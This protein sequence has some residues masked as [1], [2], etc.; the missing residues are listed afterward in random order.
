MRYK[1]I[2]VIIVLIILSAG[3]HIQYDFLQSTAE[4]ASVEIVEIGTIS[5]WDEQ[6]Q[7]CLIDQSVIGRV[8]DIPSFLEEFCAVQ[9]TL[10]FSDPKGVEEGDVAVKVTYANGDYELIGR[11]GQAKY[12]SGELGY[13]LGYRCFDEEQFHTC[14]AKY[15]DDTIME[16]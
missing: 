13:G 16:W 8:Q 4:I 6:K 3:C 7:T 15:I 9:C 14:I 1:L 5:G 12:K 10:I 2:P 11:G